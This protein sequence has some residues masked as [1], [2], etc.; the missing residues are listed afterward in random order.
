MGGSSDDIQGS[1]DDVSL[2]MI[3]RV[4]YVDNKRGIYSKQPQ[5]VLQRALY[6]MDDVSLLMICRALYIVYMHPY[7]IL[8]R[9][10]STQNSPNMYC[11]GPYISWKEPH[12]S[13]EEPYIHP[14]D[15]CI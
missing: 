14:I 1:V 15:V 4:I 6:I 7:R 5:Y 2:L 10:I 8:Y 11:K 3:Y 12:M 13:S 9:G